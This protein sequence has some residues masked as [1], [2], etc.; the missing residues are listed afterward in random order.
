MKK[1]LYIILF[2][3]TLSSCSSL[4]SLGSL[5]SDDKKIFY[6][7]AYENVKIVEQDSNITGKNVHPVQI[8]PE[9]ISGALQQFIIRVGKDTFSMF[10][11]N[12]INFVSEAISKALANAKPDEDVVFTMENWYAGLPGTRLRDNKV[13]SGRLFYKRDGL[14]LIFGSV[15]RDGFTSTTDPML[16]TRNPDLKTNPYLPGSRTISIKNP[17][18]LAAPPNT[19]IVRPKIARGRADWVVLTRQALKARAPLTPAQKQMAKATNIEVEGLRN[20]LQQLKRELQTMRGSPKQNY[21]YQQ[22][23][24]GNRQQYQQ[25]YPPVKA[26]PYPYPPNQMIYQNPNLQNIPQGNQQDNRQISLKSL[27]NM[28]SRGLISEESY[29]NKLKELGY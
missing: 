16:N 21:Y 1:F 12:K 15:L 14:N 13:V 23:Y 18:A 6:L 11:D 17:Y 7:S 22:P 2:S 25:P 27:E 19:G 4:D 29:L 5:F 10:P 8:A 3:L 26:Y 20:E 28:R 9:R 24:Y